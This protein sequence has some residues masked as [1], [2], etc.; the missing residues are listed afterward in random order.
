MNR[1]DLDRTVRRAVELFAASEITVHPLPVN[2]DLYP[3]MF[4][5]RGMET[6]KGMTV[7]AIAFDVGAAVNKMLAEVVGALKITAPIKLQK[8]A[9]TLLRE[10][11]VE[12]LHVGHGDIEVMRT[13][14]ARVF[15][16]VTAG[17]RNAEVYV[18]SKD[19]AE[20]TSE[21]VHELVDRVA[22]EL[23]IVA[24]P[25]GPITYPLA[26]A[27]DAV[28]AKVFRDVAAELSH[29]GTHGRSHRVERLGDPALYWDMI[30]AAAQVIRNA[31][32][33]RRE[34]IGDAP[35]AEVP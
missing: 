34:Y 2:G 9:A 29:P 26:A 23:G 5:Y 1:D 3:Y 14:D 30:T 13:T 10:L 18:A 17:A 33:W 19:L 22:A 12:R 20:R 8:S 31:E 27:P 16:R 6:V 32:L 35:T 4:R 15:V 21:T 11:L 28:T 25:A 24:T 7:K